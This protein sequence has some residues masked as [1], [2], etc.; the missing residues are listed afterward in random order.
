MVDEA[1]PTGGPFQK[2]VD[3]TLKHIMMAFAKKN[4]VFM[5]NV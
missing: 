1:F 5:Q 2:V 4:K 3:S